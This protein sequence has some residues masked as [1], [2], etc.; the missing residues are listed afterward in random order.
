MKEQQFTKP[1]NQ[2]K[3]YGQ[4]MAKQNPQTDRL[5]ITELQVLAMAKD[6]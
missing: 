4:V 1:Q 2:V 3:Y 5:K 6:L